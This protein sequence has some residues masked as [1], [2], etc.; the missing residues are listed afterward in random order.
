MTTNTD[1]PAAEMQT[2]RLPANIGIREGGALKEQLLPLL[3]LDDPVAIDVS[4][5]QR[6]D[7]VGLQLLFAFCR[8]RTAE[9]R[10]VIFQGDSEAMRTAVAVLNLDLDSSVS[11]NS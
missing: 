6:I 5:V 10:S 8:D 2:V 7:T 11:N 9:K 4:D 3:G 1:L